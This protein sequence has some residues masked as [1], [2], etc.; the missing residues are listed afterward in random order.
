MCFHK[1]ILFIN[2]YLQIC[3]KKPILF[4]NDYLQNI[5]I[6]YFPMYTNRLCL[7]MIIVLIYFIVEFFSLYVLLL[8]RP[9]VPNQYKYTYQSCNK[10][11]TF[12]FMLIF[13]N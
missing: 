13:S 10:V 5:L 1:P 11:F 6:I 4:I 8:L 2:D 3:F 7:I 12:L 9:E